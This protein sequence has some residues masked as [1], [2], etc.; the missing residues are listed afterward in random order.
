MYITFDPAKRE[1]TLSERGIDSAD[2]K[3]VF[4]GPTLELEDVRNDYGE[5][6]ILCYGFLDQRLVVVGYVARGEDRHVFSMRKA[7]DREQTR[8]LPLLDF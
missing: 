3:A 7:N 2:A 4:E 5:Q 6:R 8:I 1:R